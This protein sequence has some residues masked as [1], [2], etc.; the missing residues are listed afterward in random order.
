MVENWLKCLQLNEI[1]KCEDTPAKVVQFSHG[2]LWLRMEVTPIVIETLLQP[3]SL[4]NQIKSNKWLRIGGIIVN[5][6]GEGSDG[7]MMAVAL[8]EE[9]ST[10]CRP[11]IVCGKDPF[12]FLEMDG[13]WRELA[14]R[15]HPFSFSLFYLSLDSDREV[16]GRRKR[17]PLYVSCVWNEKSSSTVTPPDF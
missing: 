13:R 2:L 11:T 5:V 7:G 4:N 16:G 8:G 9:G 10:I 12:L 14:P 6:G 1:C 3:W 15:H 17:T